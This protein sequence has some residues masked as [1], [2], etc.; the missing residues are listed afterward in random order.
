MKGI[1]KLK[2]KLP[3]Y[4]GKKIY[5]F[6]ILAGIVFIC[7]LALQLII[8]SLPRVFRNSRSLGFF[9]PI[10]PIFSSLIIV[11]LGLLIIYNFW[12]VRK[13]QLIKY[14]E[15][16]YQKSFRFVVVGVSMVFSVII[17]NMFPSDL[18]VP[19]TSH[20]TLSS[21]LGRVMTDFFINTPIWFFVIRI[22]L[23]VFFTALGLIVIN[24]ALRIFGIDYMTLV[25]VYYPDESELQNHEIYSILRHPT[26]HALG[27]LCIGSIFLRFSIYSIIYFLIYI[28]GI[29]LHLKL[30]E[31]KELIERFGDSYRNYRKNV[32]ALYV[33]IKDLKSYFRFILK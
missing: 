6:L 15:L 9:A 5:R 3:D 30:V 24:R 33:K 12:R 17:H 27:L 23:F 28:I 2:R 7:S 29:T 20:D 16:A 26:Y 25:Y 13:K 10:F 32:P 1:E 22:I 18:L 21:Y 14:H 19:Y 8:D 31:E 11:T 4:P